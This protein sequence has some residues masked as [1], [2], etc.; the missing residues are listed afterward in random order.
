M[1]VYLSLVIV[2]LLAVLSPQLGTITSKKSSTYQVNPALAGLN[3]CSEDLFNGFW[4]VSAKIGNCVMIR[5]ETID[6]P[7]RFMRNYVHI[8]FPDLWMISTY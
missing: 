4:V 8:L 5:S 7:S 3:C 6:E 2:I 1:P